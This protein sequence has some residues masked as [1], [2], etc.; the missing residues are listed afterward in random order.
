MFT[1]EFD[2]RTPME[3]L[4]KDL[5]E[6]AAFFRVFASTQRA[7]AERGRTKME[8][9]SAAAAADAYEDCANIL[10]NTKLVGEASS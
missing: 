10:E 6:V 7:V 5:K 2:R 4:A 9:A 1:I 8:R 3:Y